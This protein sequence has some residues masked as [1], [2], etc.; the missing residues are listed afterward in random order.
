LA[1]GHSE[2]DELLKMAA[3]YGVCGVGSKLWA[4]RL[5]DF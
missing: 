1:G 3:V 5:A 4:A 2:K